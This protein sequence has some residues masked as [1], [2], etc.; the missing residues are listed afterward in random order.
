M[1]RPTVSDLFAHIDS[2]LAITLFRDLENGD[3]LSY[4]STHQIAAE[5]QVCQEYRAKEPAMR[6]GDG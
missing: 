3:W 4:M 1:A 2:G 6:P 5:A